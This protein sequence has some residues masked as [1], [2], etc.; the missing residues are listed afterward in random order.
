[1]EHNSG[2]DL[3][4]NGQLPI[5]KLESPYDMGL[6]TMSYN[7]Q[8]YGDGVD[9]MITTQPYTTAMISALP[10]SVVCYGTVRFLNRDSLEEEL[11]NIL[12]LERVPIVSNQ[13]G[14]YITK[15]YFS[16][17]FIDLTVSIFNNMYSLTLPD[18]TFFT[19]LDFDISDLFNSLF[20]NGLQK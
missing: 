13:S 15:K 19:I 11:T 16:L 20:E 14:S 8:T 9:D 7:H 18:G 10:E 17:D 12:Q 5:V 6:F 1:Y 2:M 4:I 3:E